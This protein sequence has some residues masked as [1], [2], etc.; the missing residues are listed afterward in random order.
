MTVTYILGYIAYRLYVTTIGYIAYRPALSSGHNTFNDLYKA[1]LRVLLLVQ[2]SPRE[3]N[4][5]A[6]EAPLRLDRV[7]R[8]PCNQDIGSSSG[9]EVGRQL[10]RRDGTYTIRSQD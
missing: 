6:D 8:R 5:L 9:R 10:P 3:P 1:P 2:I 4:S 7:S